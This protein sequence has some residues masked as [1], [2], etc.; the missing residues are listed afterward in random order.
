MFSSRIMYRAVQSKALFLQC[1]LHFHTLSIST[2]Q[3]V[4]MPSSGADYDVQL[5]TAIQDL[6]DL[7]EDLEH[8]VFFM[9]CSKDVPE[10][11]MDS[12]RVHPQ[13]LALDLKEAGFKW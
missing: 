13:R 9:Y 2:V 10:D 3:Q 5:E 12:D 8:D 7:H 11:I 4:L 1:H 6:E